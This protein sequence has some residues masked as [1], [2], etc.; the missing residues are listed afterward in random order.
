MYKKIKEMQYGIVFR[1]SDKIWS[2]VIARGHADANPDVKF[3]VINCRG[4]HMCAYVTFPD[5]C[6]V[7]DEDSIWV[8]SGGVHGGFTFY[9]KVACANDGITYIGWDYAHLGDFTCSGF[10]GID[11]PH[12]ANGD[13][14]WTLD[15]VCQE[16]E[17]V[18]NA[19][20]AGKYDIAGYDE[21][22]EDD[23][24]TEEC[25]PM[26]NVM[27]SLPCH[28]RTDGELDEIVDSL[29]RRI[30]VKADFVCL[31]KSM[32]KECDMDHITFVRSNPLSNDLPD[33]F[34]ILQ[35]TIL[36][37]VNNK[38]LYYLGSAIN[39][40]SGCDAVYFVDGWES[41]KGCCVEKLVCDLYDIPHLVERKE[42]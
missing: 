17:D 33:G 35:E 28:G 19:I 14:K 31:F 24:E 6:K 18:A 32:D 13:H 12:L 37:T 15:E 25:I 22:D 1:E 38:R 11:E 29:N 39:T 40:M 41:A 20:A 34:K 26:R 21:E 16:A 9:G 2:E 5:I 42:D 7:P 23:Y 10:P 27:V 30:D 8:E 4:S 36:D 3:I